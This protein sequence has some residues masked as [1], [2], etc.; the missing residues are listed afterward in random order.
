MTH[1]DFLQINS[2]RAAAGMPPIVRKLR[3]CLRCDGRF[4]S[5]GAHNRICSDCR[6]TA[7]SANYIRKE[8]PKE[9][10]RDAVVE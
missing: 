8:S 9:E 4:E 2:L 6:H 1:D 7:Q 3:I 10:E 5:A